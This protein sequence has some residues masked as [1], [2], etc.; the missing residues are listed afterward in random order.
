MRIQCSAVPQ[1][2]L[3]R[4]KAPC[5]PRC[6]SF[7]S[8]GATGFPVHNSGGPPSRQRSSRPLPC[9]REPMR[10]NAA[11]SAW[12][13]L[14]CHCFRSWARAP[15]SVSVNRSSPC[16]RLRHFRS[17]I[18][19]ANSR[20]PARSTHLHGPFR[21]GAWRL[22]I[23]FIQWGCWIWRIP[24]WCRAPVIVHLDVFA[25]RMQYGGSRI[26]AAAIGE[27]RFTSATMLKH[28]TRPVPF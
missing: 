3:S 23:P 20:T 21:G 19:H 28:R 11:D 7:H 24:E 22:R 13:L 17:G 16:L 15:Y 25:R 27:L 1:P 12:G 10:P 9:S 14:V 5:R 4:D 18:R 8:K 6:P 26:L 2:R